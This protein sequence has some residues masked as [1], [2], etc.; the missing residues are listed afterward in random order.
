MMTTQSRAGSLI[1]NLNEALDTVSYKG[2][3][4][5]PDGLTELED[6]PTVKQMDVAL[7]FMDT[8]GNHKN[9]VYCQATLQGKIL[10]VAKRSPHNPARIDAG[11]MKTLSKV[12]FRWFD[13]SDKFYNF[14]V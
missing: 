9:E 2:T 13:T 8:I 7:K 11:M 1:A 10:M 5:I 14:G 12:D 6:M 4:F 3:D